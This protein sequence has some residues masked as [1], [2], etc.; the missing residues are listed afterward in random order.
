MKHG[1]SLQFIESPTR[2][3]A[4]TVSRSATRTG[5]G[6]ISFPEIRSQIFILGCASG[7]HR[8]G[9]CILAGARIIPRR[10]TMK[11]SFLLMLL[12]TV[13]P[14]VA[15]DGPDKTPPIPFH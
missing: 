3:A 11:N 14:L 13:G 8:D 15:A 5:G 6:R 4:I 7:P 12:L 1:L 2:R 9:G 10:V